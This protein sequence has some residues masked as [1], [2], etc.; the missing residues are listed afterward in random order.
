MQISNLITRLCILIF[1]YYRAFKLHYAYKKELINQ[2][3]IVLSETYALYIK[4]QSDH[5]NITGSNFYSLHRMLEDQC[6]DLVNA[7][8][9]ISKKYIYLIMRC[10]LALCFLITKNQQMA[11]FIQI[12]RR[13]LLVDLVKS[14]SIIIKE[15]N[16]LASIS[17][18]NKDS[19]SEEIST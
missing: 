13:S 12:N 8:D 19:T 6:N 15:L 16:L 3:N 17:F 4:T 18:P 7:I 2:F 5:W 1:L 11:L 9:V 14:E 10:K